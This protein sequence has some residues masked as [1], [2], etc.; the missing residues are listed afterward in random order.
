MNVEEADESWERPGEPVPAKWG[1]LTRHE[2]TRLSGIR[3]SHQM[4]LYELYGI[5]E[6]D[7]DRVEAAVEQNSHDVLAERPPRP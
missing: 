3:H 2:R 1:N 6:E 7:A 5:R 4:K